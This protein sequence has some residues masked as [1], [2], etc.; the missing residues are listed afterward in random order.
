MRSSKD[1][2]LTRDQFLKLW[3]V[4]REAEELD[5][6]ILKSPKYPYFHETVPRVHRSRDEINPNKIT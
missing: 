3:E 4:A 1:D 5:R 2:S 6:V